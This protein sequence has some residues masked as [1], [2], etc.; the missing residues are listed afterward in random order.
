M[1]RGHKH[2]LDLKA[3]VLAALL[4]GTSPPVAARQF[5]VPL[6]TVYAW[7]KEPRVMAVTGE[8]LNA[9]RVQVRDE[10]GEDGDLKRP[11]SRLDSDA[12]GALLGEYLAAGLRALRAQAEMSADREWFSSQNAAD[13]AMFHGVLADKVIRILSALRAA[14]ESSGDKTPG[15]ETDE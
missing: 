15:E 4:A 10:D 1:A 12:L 8:I 3:Q 7:R 5:S 9:A 2:D 14:E 13:L 6:T 11:G